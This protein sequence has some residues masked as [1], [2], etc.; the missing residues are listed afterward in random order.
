MNGVVNMEQNNEEIKRYSRK[1]GRMGNSLGLSL[2]KNLAEKL[3]VTQG[4]EVEFIENSQGEVVL[5]KV[6]S[7]GLPENIRP[8]VLEAFFDVF[9]QDIEIFKDLKD[10]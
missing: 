3:G 1:V 8:E 6:R 10:R 5:R 2:P 9:K 7:V 4:D